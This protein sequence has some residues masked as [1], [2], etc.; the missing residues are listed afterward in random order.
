MNVKPHSFLLHDHVAIVIGAS[1]G[2]GYAIACGLL[3][4]GACY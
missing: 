1:R 3:A 4:A 2:I